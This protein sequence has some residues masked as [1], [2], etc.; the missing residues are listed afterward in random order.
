M[1]Q[2]YENSSNGNINPIYREVTVGNHTIRITYLENILPIDGADTRWEKFEPV[3][4]PVAPEGWE[5]ELYDSIR[6]LNSVR[7]LL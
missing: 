7:H 2:Q 4:P 3:G 1:S 6:D 5:N